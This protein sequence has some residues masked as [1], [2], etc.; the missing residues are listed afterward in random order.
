MPR[1]DGTGPTGM[2]PMTGRAAGYCTGYGFPGYANPA[3]GRG[4]GA[5][6]GRGRG[7]FGSGGRGWRNRFYATGM[8]GWARY[9]GYG[10]G[11]FP[12]PVQQDPEAEK[13]MLKAQADALEAE[14][15]MIRQRLGGLEKESAEK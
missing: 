1:G 8:P 13:Q 11:A 12:P 14:L 3:F 6:F 15:Q 4:F 5:G 10:Y 7:F 2:G 9:G